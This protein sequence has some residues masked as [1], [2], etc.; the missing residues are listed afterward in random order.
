VHG[1]IDSI[2]R[3]E[4]RP[5][6]KLAE[7]TAP[8]RKLAERALEP[9]VF[10][11]PSFAMPAAPVFGSDVSAALVWSGSASP[12]LLGFFPARIERRRYAIGMPVLVG[13]THP[14]APLGAPLV[15]R[16]N[17]GRVI[18]AWLDDVARHPH[19]PKLMLLPYLPAEGP[20]AGAFEGAL[21]ARAAR[22]VRFARHARAVLAPGN[23][24]ESYLAGAI[25]RKKRK[26]LRRQRKRLGE[27]GELTLVD[28]CDAPA[29]AGAFDDFLLLEARGWKGRAGTAAR[30][31]ECVARFMHRAVTSLASEGKARILRLCTEGR[32]IA[33]ILTLRSGDT[34]WCWKI[35]Y[36]EGKARFSPGVQVLL[37]ETEIL[38][39]DRSIV[40]TDSCAT[41]GHPMI[42][43]IWRER[44][45]LADRLI[46]LGPST[47]I[48]F[49]LA[50]GLEGL[51]RC[52]IGA[53]TTMRNAS[54]SRMK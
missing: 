12:Q 36:D 31:D 45:A 18:G 35:A 44:R 1:R 13:W 28:A 4:W 29:V 50:C 52:A 46:G 15:D 24:R 7:L 53:A 22:S 34:A 40:Q 25:D 30:C 47:S 9:N 6:A 54:F 33:S 48:R 38:L 20:L 39:A 3:V 16:E 14:Y 19:L 27:C 42:D 41:A 26:E 37:D 49:A 51:R 23:K 17:C 43:H 10:Y 2:L 11:E 5:L 32:P 21:A 8:W